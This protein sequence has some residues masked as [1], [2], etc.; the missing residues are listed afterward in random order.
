VYIEDITIDHVAVEAALNSR[1]SAPQDM[2]VWGL[3]E[4]A[5]NM[6]KLAAW[7]TDKTQR[8]EN[9]EIIED[10]PERPKSIPNSVE[11]IRIASFRY[12]VHSSNNIQTFPVDQEIKAL[13]IDFGVVALVIKSNWGNSAFT[14]LYRFRVHGQRMGESPYPEL[15]P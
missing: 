13:G 3:I 1:A 2:E 7:R 11:Y 6:A 12:N 4:G 15:N 14:C 9:G 5:D 8:R 10:E